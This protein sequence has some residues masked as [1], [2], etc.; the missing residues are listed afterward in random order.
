MDGQ[1]HSPEGENQ[2]PVQEKRL[3]FF[4][5]FFTALGSVLIFLLD[6]DR[7]RELFTLFRDIIVH[8]LIAS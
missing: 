1:D 3:I 7:A 8:L 4:A 5:V 6:A 2:K